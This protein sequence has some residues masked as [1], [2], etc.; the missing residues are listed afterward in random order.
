MLL[1]MLKLTA[2]LEERFLQTISGIFFSWVSTSLID[3][4]TKE[5]D[6]ETRTKLRKH[7]IYDKYFA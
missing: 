1:K 6:V 3:A 7:S 4:H 2:P 5:M